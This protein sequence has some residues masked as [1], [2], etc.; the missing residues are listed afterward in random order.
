MI[1]S[2]NLKLNEKM[3][4]TYK[5]YFSPPWFLP[6][7]RAR[8]NKG[9]SCRKPCGDLRPFQKTAYHHPTVPFS[10]G[11][12]YMK[13]IVFGVKYSQ[14]SRRQLGAPRRSRSWMRLS[15]GRWPSPADPRAAPTSRLAS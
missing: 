15:Q 8:D 12:G 1:D 7:A 13:Y 2:Q 5:D 6:N 11:R 3:E 10:V 4:I 9:I 14:S